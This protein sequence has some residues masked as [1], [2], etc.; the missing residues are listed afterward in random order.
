M[1]FASKNSIV[2]YFFLAFSFKNVDNKIR[3]NTFVDGVLN[4][5][6]QFGTAIGARNN[7]M[8]ASIGALVAAYDK[9]AAS[10]DAPGQGHGKL[11]GYLDEF[12]YWKKERTAKS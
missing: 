7:T 12:R 3:V 2:S 9:N 4:D 6:R 5:T 8:V 1:L 11:S 10:A